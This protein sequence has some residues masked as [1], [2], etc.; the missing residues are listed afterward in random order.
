MLKKLI[1]YAVPISIFIYTAAFLLLFPYY[2]FIFDPDAIGY[3]AVAERVADG[4]Y[5]E[6]V[7]GLW[8]PLSSWLAV[9]LIKLGIDTLIAFK[10]INGITGIF[11][12]LFTFKLLNKFILTDWLKTMILYTCVLIFLSYCFYELCADFLLLLFFVLYLI[13]ISSADFFQNKKRIFFCS[14]IAV[15][16][17]LSKAYFFPFFLAHFLL[18]NFYHYKISV[19]TNKLKIF[20]RNISIGLITFLF[21]CTPWIYALSVKYGYV[22]YSNTGKYNTYLHLHTISLYEKLVI[23]PPYV[24][25]L[26]SWDDPWQPFMKDFSVFSSFTNII[27]QIKLFFINLA[28]SPPYFTEISFLCLVIIAAII[29]FSISKKTIFNIPRNVRLL[30]ITAILMPLGYLLFHLETR[31]IWIESILCLIAGAYLISIAFNNFLFTKAQKAF[32]LLIFFGSFLIGPLQSLKNGINSGKENY[33]LAE[34]FKKNNITGKVMSNYLNQDQYR[35]L[36]MSNVI[37]KNQFYN[38]SRPDF[39]NEDILASIKEFDIDYFIFSFNNEFEKDLFITSNL[40]K[41]AAASI[42]GIYPGI[43]VLKLK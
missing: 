16:A 34:A 40:Y 9:P 11:L 27:N 37:A 12:L 15:G 39:S 17:Y 33:E 5:F 8:S 2:K 26:N 41:S 18:I 19:A 23:P 13:Q 22:T 4:N 1:Q 31:F 32:L 24:D 36:L 35:T 25:A 6:S 43:M 38:Y 10:Y 30:I 29:F 3:S 7:N 20:F 42:K 21:L 14:L 28:G